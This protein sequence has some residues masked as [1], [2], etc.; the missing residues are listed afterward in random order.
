MTS[1][2]PTPPTASAPAATPK[3]VRF[4]RFS[5]LLPFALIT[6]L[7]VAGYLIFFDRLVKRGLEATFT[8][9][10]GARVEI[11]SFDFSLLDTSVQTRGIQWT[12]ADAPMKNLFEIGATD[13]TLQSSPWSVGKFVVTRMAVEDLR[14]DTERTTSGA[15]PREKNTSATGP[16]TDAGASGNMA[17]SIEAFAKGIDYQAIAGK[18]GQPED[19]PAVR[20]GK[21]LEDKVQARSDLW[22]ERLPGLTDLSDLQATSDEIQAISRR[23]YKLPED[24]PQLRKDLDT[25]KDA[26]QRLHAKQDA[27]KQARQGLQTDM[28][29]LQAGYAQV[30]ALREAKL[31]DLLI[32]PQGDLFSA[33]NILSALLGASLVDSARKYL[34]YYDK[35]KGYLPEQKQTAEAK[36]VQQE[37]ARGT[38]VDFVRAGALPS[39]YIG[40]IDVSGRY[41]TAVLS[42]TVRNASSDLT[43]QPLLLNVDF[44]D[45]QNNANLATLSGSMS[46]TKQGLNSNIQLSLR[47]SPLQ[48]LTS[49][50]DNKYLAGMDGKADIRAVLNDTPESL[51]LALRIEGRDVGLKLKPDSMGKDMER[52][53]SAVLTRIDLLTVDLAYVRTTGPDGKLR[54]TTRLRSNLEPLLNA[55]LR[56]YVDAEVAKFNREL[57]TRFD[58]EVDQALAPLKQKLDGFDQSGT[59]SAA[60]GDADKLDAARAKLEQDL[61]QKIK[62]EENR[63]KSKANDRLDKQKEKLENKLKSLR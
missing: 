39:V 62:A 14:F 36:V 1:S 20:L 57:R 4:F 8:A 38:T 58:A 49:G 42:G 27:L 3:K 11:G 28:N 25:L 61:E 47:Q 13:F 21:E 19:I 24:L 55:R 41:E 22:K 50:V 7:I 18:I 43:Y 16:S 10:N 56:A 31:K 17:A 30:N 2:T 15:L 54:T 6:A 59:L 45:A 26:K 53:L 40:Q 33:S 34:G 37:R 23:K 63:L 48:R 46:G 32:D 29:E 60:L 35:F 44:R 12:D 5:A 51:S 9:M 52:L